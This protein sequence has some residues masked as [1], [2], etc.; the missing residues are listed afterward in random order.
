MNTNTATEYRNLPLAVLTESA[1]NPR[2]IFED[3]ALKELAESI[4]SQGV[5]SPLLVSSNR[6]HILLVR[7]VAGDRKDSS[8]S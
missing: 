5:L 4:R 6:A 3:S 2:R 7:S 8:P 1:T